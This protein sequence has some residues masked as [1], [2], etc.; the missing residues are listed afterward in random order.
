VSITRLILRELSRRKVN[1][2]LSLVS[3]IAAVTCLTAAL[4]ILRGHDVRTDEILARMQAQSQQHLD[5]LR[6]ATEQS[7][8]ALLEEYRK[9]VLELGF[10]VFIVPKRAANADPGAAPPQMPY[11]YVQRLANADILTIEH[12]LPSLSLPVY[13]QEQKQHITLT[14]IHGEVAIAGKKRKKP[15]I[16]PVEP[17]QIVLGAALAKDTGLKRGDAVTLLGLPLTVSLVHPVRGT[18]DDRTAWIDLKQ[19]QQLLN[20]DGVITGIQAIN[21]LAPNCHPDATGIPSVTAEITNVL[22]DTQVI[23]DMAKAKTR[24]DAR[25]AA[26]A[27]AKAA[28]EKEDA[29]AAG[30]LALE[31]QRRS[32][33]RGQIEQFAAVLIPVMVVAA[34]LAI[35]LLTFMNTRERRGEVGILRALGVSS[36]GVLAMFLGK[37]VTLGLAGAV[38]GY[39]LGVAVGAAVS[40]ADLSRLIDP[41]GPVLILILAPLLAA[42]ASWLPSM[43]AAQQ[44]PAMVLS[45]Q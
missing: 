44:D 23:I 17:G 29:R 43:H 1:A 31:R 27:H 7:N 26:A 16:Q 21:C 37:A 30:A 19:A 40:E 35:G 11:D 15:L 18:Q 25:Q 45:E 39:G 13:W 33:I 22:P 32:E 3:V 14:G 28:L 8:A 36:A 9:I 41:I 6:A 20:K 34:A 4:A 5:A 24:I 38:A 2:A 12:L 42:V 10:N